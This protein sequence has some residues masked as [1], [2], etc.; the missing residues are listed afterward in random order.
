M[1]IMRI[2]HAQPHRI[3]SAPYVAHVIPTNTDQTVHR[4]AVV[5]LV[6]IVSYV[7]QENISQDAQDGSRVR[8]CPVPLP[9]IFAW[10]TTIYPLHG[11]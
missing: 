9:I 4:L 11:K 10:V 6:V 2:C 3:D 7:L 8:V 1:D 5:V